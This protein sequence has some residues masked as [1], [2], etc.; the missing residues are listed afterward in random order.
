[1]ERNGIEVGT[2][3]RTNRDLTKGMLGIH[4]EI[5]QHDDVIIPRGWRGEV[6][7]IDGSKVTCASP[8]KRWTC[9]MEYLDPE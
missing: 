6:M 3:I 5:L 9:S 1:M 7:E 8:S 2:I 4:D